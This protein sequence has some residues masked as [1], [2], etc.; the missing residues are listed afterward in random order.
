MRVR[1][2]PVMALS[3]MSPWL[4]VTMTGPL[5]AVIVDV[6][7]VGGDGGRG[8][9]GHGDDEVGAGAFDGGDVEGDVCCR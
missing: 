4:A 6:A 1:E 5:M 9:G 2:G 7:V 8:G 3:S